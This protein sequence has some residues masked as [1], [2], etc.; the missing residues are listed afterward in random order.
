[1][2]SGVF[3]LPKVRRFLLVVACALALAAAGCVEITN[4]QFDA[5]YRSAVRPVPKLPYAVFAVY[6]TPAQ[7]VSRTRSA[8]ILVIDTAKGSV[9][10]SVT[11]EGVVGLSDVGGPSNSRA[12]GPGGRLRPGQ[13]PL[14]RGHP[15]AHGVA[16]RRR[17]ARRRVRRQG[18]PR[19]LADRRRRSGVARDAADRRERADRRGG[20]P[21]R[22]E[23][24]AGARVGRRRHDADGRERA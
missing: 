4:P 18:H 1:M 8:T 11:L 19:V 22:R 24:L 16:A 23:Q 20:L 12:R 3:P 6:H 9:V 17:A 21:D 13:P 2:V 14:G 7:V 5:R 10:S 15:P